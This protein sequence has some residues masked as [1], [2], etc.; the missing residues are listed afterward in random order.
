MAEPA[1]YVTQPEHHSHCPKPDIG[2]TQCIDDDCFHIRRLYHPGLEADLNSRSSSLLNGI[3][4]MS[5]QQQNAW[6]S[7]LAARSTV[8]SIY[9][10]LLT[11]QTQFLQQI[12]NL[13]NSSTDAQLIAAALSFFSDVLSSALGAP[14][15]SAVVLDPVNLYADKSRLSVFEQQYNSSFG[16][17]SQCIDYGGAIWQNAAGAYG[18]ITDSAWPQTATGQI[19]QVTNY[20]QGSTM[21]FL[22]SE[23]ASCSDV[24]VTN[25][26]T[27]QA[28]FTVAVQYS[29]VTTQVVFDGW[30]KN[31]RPSRARRRYSSTGRPCLR[32]VQM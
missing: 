7:D 14:G 17:L 27:N 4:P 32:S 24:T 9:V 18:G 23:N 29:H 31:G 21:L 16:T 10:D 19:L 15:L 6:A 13:N 22:W 30:G 8:P 5:G 12:Q 26:G 28:T 3:P 1:D 20:S 11:Q 2:L 25:T